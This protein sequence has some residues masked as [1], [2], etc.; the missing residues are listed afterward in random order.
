MLL[1]T[2]TPGPPLGAFVEL[3]WLY[4]TRVPH[5]AERLLPT[6]SMELVVTLTGRPEALVAGAYSRFA[7]LDTSQP[8]LVLGA[9]FRP[10][11]AYPFLRMPAGELHNLDVSLEDLWGAA[12]ARVLHE[13]LS[14]APAPQQKFDLLERALIAHATTLERKG[15][16]PW[17][18]GE[19]RRARVTDVTNAIGM[20]GR[21]FIEAFRRETGYTP[22]V[23]A[24]VQRFQRLLRRVHRASVVDWADVALA[25]GYY[26]QSHLIRDFR[27][28]SGLTPAEYLIRRGDHLNHVP[29]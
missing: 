16:V 3:L 23:Y 26:D 25:C 20:S 13:R 27:A 4:D 1:A 28:F 8:A 29:M 7:I 15:A 22:K 11:G 21:G 10:G 17:A 18:V 2:R 24:R 12:A 9:H 19:L 14:A 5:A 6:G